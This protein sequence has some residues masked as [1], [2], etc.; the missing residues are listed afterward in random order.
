MPKE[1][2]TYGLFFM[3]PGLKYSK[4][5]T[6]N[7]RFIFATTITLV[8]KKLFKFAV[9]FKEKIVNLIWQWRAFPL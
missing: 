5:V 6:E 2:F 8:R 9:K 4:V 7:Q 3:N 1:L